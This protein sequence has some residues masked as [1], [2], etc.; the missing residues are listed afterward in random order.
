[1]KYDMRLLYTTDTGIEVRI[2]AEIDSVTIFTQDGDHQNRA[3]LSAQDAT[4]LAN[5]FARAAQHTRELNNKN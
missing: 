1:M 2:D 4:E 5:M 3:T